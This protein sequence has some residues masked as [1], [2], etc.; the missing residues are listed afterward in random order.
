MSNWR[1]VYN[2]SDAKNNNHHIYKNRGVWWIHFTMV[3]VAR[4][5]SGRQRHTLKTR[6]VEKARKRR[7]NIIKAVISDYGR[8]ENAR[9]RNR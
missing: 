8:I 4:N 3:N 2:D 5:V 7:D 6:D 9:S 1:L